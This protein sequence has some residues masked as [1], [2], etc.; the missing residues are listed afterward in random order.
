[1]TGFVEYESYDA[2]GLAAL[3]R[4]RAVNPG[5]LLDA[6]IERTDAQNPALNAVVIRLYDHA[7][8][9]IAAGLPDGPL[10]GVPF[11]LKDL[12][13]SCAGTPCTRGSKLYEG[14]ICDH[15]STLVARYKRA[16]LVI[17]GRTNSPEFGVSYTTEPALY[18]PTRDPWRLDRTPGGSS[19]GAAA[20]VAARIVPAAHASDGGGS[21]RVPASC[22]GLFGLKPTRGRVPAGPDRGESWAGMSVTHALTRSVRDSAA[23]LDAVAGPDVGDPYWA[24]LP[25]R[26]FRDEVSADPGRLR[27]AVSAAPPNGVPVHADC[28]AALDRAAKLCADLGHDIAEAEPAFDGTA[29]DEARLTVIRAHLTA[30][31]DERAREIGRSVLRDDVEAMTWAIAH[32]G[33][34]VS[35]GE[36]VAAV[37]A[38]HR[39]GRQ[40]ARFFL[41][42]EVLIT[43]VLATTPLAIGALDPMGG[44]IDAYLDEMARFAAFPPLSNVTGAPAMSVPLDW[45]AEGLPIGVQFVG[46]FGDEATLFRLAAQLEDAAPWSGRRPEAP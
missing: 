31:L 18:G 4:E 44:D 16:G 33:E 29:M 35:G 2:L 40:V 30:D 38:M 19:G 1:M 32:R 12:G 14:H 22:C 23:L 8:A 28:R 26:P 21:I 3:V 7:K 27:I 24:P 5:E 10:A 43:P 46:R 45:N 6:A 37:Q 34:P 9:A 36:Y 20:A 39:I 17:F 15:D 42:Y 41:D 13:A 11:L 25:V